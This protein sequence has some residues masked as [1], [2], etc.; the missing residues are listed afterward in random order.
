VLDEK[1]GNGFKL[2]AMRTDF[3]RII[4]PA[5]FGWAGIFPIAIE[6]DFISYHNGFRIVSH[7]SVFLSLLAAV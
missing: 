6:T 4:P 2:G 7:L 1:F 3:G 5:S